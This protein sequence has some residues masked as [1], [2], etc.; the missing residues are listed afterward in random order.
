M[1]LY[2]AAGPSFSGEEVVAP[3]EY[4]ERLRRDLPRHLHIDKMSNE[5]LQDNLL[6][7]NLTPRKGLGFK[8]PAQAILK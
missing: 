5:E 8:T 1:L 2:Q 4:I 6:T 7:H 3:M